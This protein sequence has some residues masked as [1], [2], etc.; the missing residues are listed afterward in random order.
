MSFSESLFYR[1][2]ADHYLQWRPVNFGEELNLTYLSLISC[3]VSLFLESSL[4]SD[5]QD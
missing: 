3:L 2:S 4:S 1:V 5:L